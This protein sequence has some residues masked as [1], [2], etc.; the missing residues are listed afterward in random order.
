MDPDHAGLRIQPTDANPSRSD[1]AAL[2]RLQQYCG[3]ESAIL[4]R[5]MDPDPTHL[6]DDMDL[7]NK[8]L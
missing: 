4:L 3:S 7:F 8:F 1:S 6:L 5:D 2:L